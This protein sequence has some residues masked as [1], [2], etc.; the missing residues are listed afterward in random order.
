MEALVFGIELSI[1]IFFILL[2]TAVFY[3][4]L[5]VKHNSHNVGLFHNTVLVSSFLLMIFQYAYL[6]YFGYT[7]SWGSML[8][9][10]L[11][12]LIFTSIASYFEVKFLKENYRMLLVKLSLPT[13]WISFGFLT[14][15]MI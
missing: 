9:L 2:S 8:I 12:Y 7:V 10:G 11:L 15:R 4:Q 5:Y 3:L 6:I 13:A 14:Y 1:I